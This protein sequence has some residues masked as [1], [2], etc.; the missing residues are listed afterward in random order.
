[1]VR[2]SVESPAVAQLIA[3]LERYGERTF[4]DKVLTNL[5]DDVTTHLIRAMPVPSSGFSNALQLHEWVSEQA[6]YFDELVVE[7]KRR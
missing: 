4:R 3:S 1:M 6:E 5:F 7:D 2:S